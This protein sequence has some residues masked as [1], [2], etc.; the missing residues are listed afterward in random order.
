MVLP[1]NATGSGHLQLLTTPKSLV[2][3]WMTQSAGETP[4][5]LSDRTRAIPESRRPRKLNDTAMRRALSPS[6]R[7][8]S[9]ELR[10]VGLM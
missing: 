7:T 6:T 4:A 5:A 2:P 9:A 3:N 10:R 8:F 1:A